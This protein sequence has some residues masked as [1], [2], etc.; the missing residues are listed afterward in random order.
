MEIMWLELLVVHMNIHPLAEAPWNLKP[1][2]RW[3]VYVIDRAS[4]SLKLLDISKSVFDGIREL[5]R[6]D[7]WGDTLGY[8]INIKVNKNAG[9]AVGYYTVIPKSKSPLSPADLELKQNMDLDDLKRRCT[10]PSPEDV[11]KKIAAIIAKS[12]F[13]APTTTNT[14]VQNAVNTTVESND[15]DFDFPVVSG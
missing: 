1:S 6:D 7:S 11:D 4:Q 12:G 3:L 8:D 9:G 2:R 5:V 15:E 10:P 13:T 14:V